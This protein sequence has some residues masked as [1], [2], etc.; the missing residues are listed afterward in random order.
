MSPADR[1]RSP[2]RIDHL[3]DRIN[4]WPRPL[5][6]VVGIVITLELTVLAWLVLAWAFDVA[7]LAV[8]PDVT[9]PLT[10]VIVLGLLF[11]G[12]GW[13]AMVG[14]DMHPETPW[15]AGRPAVWFVAGGA[16]GLV[17][18]IMLVLFGLAFGYLM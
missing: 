16:A 9:A 7:V 17:S 4:R 2:S 13:F 1:S 11:Y 15:R 5:R 10:I 6:I 3:A 8:D 12:F 18:I 14:F